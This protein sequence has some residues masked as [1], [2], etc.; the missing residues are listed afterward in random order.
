MSF[1]SKV[2]EELTPILMHLWVSGLK[3]ARFPHLK[4]SIGFWTGHQLNM[5]AQPL[6]LP[7]NEYSEPD[8]DFSRAEIKEK[9]Y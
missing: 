4:N 1:S 6:L 3:S 2:V 7:A 9:E 5:G 8:F